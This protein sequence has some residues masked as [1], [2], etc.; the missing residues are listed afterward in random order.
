MT[1]EYAGNVYD[2]VF[3]GVARY[4]GNATAR[5]AATHPLR[6]GALKSSAPWCPAAIYQDG[7]D[8][9]NR[10]WWVYLPETVDAA[11]P[12]PVVFVFHGAGGSA[13]EIAD[14][15]GWG[16]LAQKV[17][18]YDHLPHGFGPQ[19]GAPCHQ[20]RYQRDV[21][22]HVEYRRRRARSAPTIC[23]LSISCTTG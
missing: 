2:L 10:H 17:W 12:Y 20:H 9:Y 18:L 3:A 4:P 5:C 7:R 23:S 19:P 21:P 8:V 6:S 11:K 1:A 15:T 16:D 13:D 22:R 14:R